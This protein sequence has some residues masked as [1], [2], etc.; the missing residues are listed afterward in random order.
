M[1]KHTG[2]YLDFCCDSH[3]RYYWRKHIKHPKNKREHRCECGKKIKPIKC[4]HCKE[5]LK[6]EFR[7]KECLRK[8]RKS[9]NTI[10]EDDSQKE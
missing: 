7:C 2:E 8:N 9:Q 1:N 10:K 5:I 4:P 3:R 6:Y